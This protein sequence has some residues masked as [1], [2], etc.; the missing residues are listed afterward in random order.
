MGMQMD[1]GS[2]D[3]PRHHRLGAKHVTLWRLAG[4]A[5]LYM[6]QTAKE[7]KAHSAL[8]ADCATG[9]ETAGHQRKSE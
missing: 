3:V 7:T 5:R 8:V 4:C 1:T 9:W 6:P 2:C